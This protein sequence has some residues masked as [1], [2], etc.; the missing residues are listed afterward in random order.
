MIIHGQEIQSRDVEGA[1]FNWDA[2]RFVGLC[3]D[4]VWAETKRHTGKIPLMTGCIFVADNGVDAEWIGTPRRGHR[5]SGRFLRPGT[6]VFQYKIRSASDSS[7][8]AIVSTLRS[9]LRGAIAEVEERTGKTVTSYIFFTNVDMTLPQQESLM[10]AIR[11]GHSREETNVAILGAAHLASAL[12]DLPHLRS[13]Y[14]VTHDFRTWEVAW[15]THAALV[16]SGAEIELVGRDS[17]LEQLINWVDDP[18]VRAVI[19]TGP[20]T[21]GKTRLALEA[22]R[23]RRFDFVEALGR[24][25]TLVTDL[26]DLH[27]STGETVVLL[28]DPDPD[29]AKK[30]VDDVLAQPNLRLL[31]TVPTSDT[32]AAPN[33]GY[34]ARVRQ[35]SLDPLD[36]EAARKLLQSV[37]EQIDYG[38]ATWIAQM[39]GGVP[40]ILLAAASVGRELRE[41]PGDFLTNVASALET[42]A[43][44]RL[45]ER[46]FEALQLLSCL[47]FVGVEGNPQ[48]ELRTIC[49]VFGADLRV[50]L[51]SIGPLCAT[52]FLRRNGSYV[53]VAPPL[54]ANHLAEG[55]FRDYPEAPSALFRQADSA[56]LRLFL[57]RMVQLRRAAVEAFWNSFVQPSG[58]FGSLSELVA[59]ASL[60]HRCATS[61]PARFAT[62]VADALAGAPLD[63]RL[64]I[65]GDAR[66]DLVW[67]LEQM[68]FRSDMSEPA[69]R[70]LGDLAEAENENYGN[71]ATGIFS[72]AFHPHHSQMPLVLARRLAVLRSFM[73]S[74]G[75]ESRTLVGLEACKVALRRS[76]TISLTPSSGGQPP[77]TMPTMT[78]GEIWQYLRE[79]LNLIKEAT[80]DARERVR[81][82]AKE[83]LPAAAEDLVSQGT[84][85]QAVEA[86]EEM[87]NSLLD[88]DFE[89]DASDVA[90][91]L[92]RGRENLQKLVEVRPD[93]APYLDR[94]A[95]A[96]ERLDEA[97][98]E[99]RLRRLV[100][101]WSFVDEEGETATSG[102]ER[103]SARIDEL[104]QDACADRSLLDDDSVE[105]LLSGKAQ[106]AGEFWTNLGKHD[107]SRCWAVRVEALARDDRG[108][109][110]L[111]AYLFG[112]RQQDAVSASTWFK[113]QADS[114]KIS[115]RAI[116]LGTLVAEDADE[117]AVRIAGLL[118]TQEVEPQLVADVI[119]TR[120]W[121]ERVTEDSLLRVLAEIVGSGFERAGL[122]LQLIEFRFH[123]R[124]SIG[125]SLVDFLWRCLEVR[126]HISHHNAEYYCDILAARL[127]KLDPERGFAL[128]DR[129]LRT[130]FDT[131]AWNPLWVGPRHRFWDTLCEIDRARA[132]VIALEAA[133]D[134]NLLLGGE[135][136]G[137][138]IDPEADRSVLLEFAARGE[139]EASIVAD[140]LARRPTGFWQL[141]FALVE[142]Y[143]HSQS[144]LSKLNWG[145]RGLGEVIAG[146][147]SSH[148]EGCRVEVERALTEEAPPPLARSWLEERVQALDREIEAE[149]R[150]EADEQI[151][152]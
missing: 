49:E 26:Y 139:R 84:L 1:T 119:L 64:E 18:Q 4:L 82:R 97:P 143:P 113:I 5:R 51:N 68:L 77:G 138:V 89:F 42:R 56:G 81:R 71:N 129:S 29:I 79:V 36:D 145:L 53:E 24:H 39:A 91:A 23:H 43:R 104:A 128:L 35:L 115:P 117:A 12:N 17:Q 106:R 37:G 95:R 96:R 28:D 147:M 59:N 52:G 58:P 13:A 69:L 32:V 20:P 98:Y 103:Q 99:V 118:V 57:R 114:G 75:P 34:D 132:L 112:W 144:V 126:P 125:A 152:W 151:N 122:I 127:T 150:R 62:Q 124:P 135:L 80:G 90:D 123:V 140:T 38:L 101:G 116:L 110:V 146:P 102:Y 14:F 10:H 45:T 141:A 31:L 120:G 88:G 21:I 66:R 149:R 67:G 8:R 54:L 130:P 148:L 9:K 61:L 55:L 25:A 107:T 46:E 78:Y 121:L 33:F 142:R 105:W 22:T 60:F 85:D 108:A 44:G 134:D 72:S 50:L 11:H 136:F 7:R 74:S 3:N 83:L 137:G 92:W 27:G 86:L 111:Q 87:L 93:L 133:N 70:G 73:S 76:I 6:N 94:L 100:A 48:S 30:L 47:S 131:Q 40:G 65:L 19:L 15:D 2:S 109:N 63:I 16:V 41:R